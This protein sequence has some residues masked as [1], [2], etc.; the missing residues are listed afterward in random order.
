ML[1]Q[2]I[3]GKFPFDYKQFGG[4]MMGLTKAVQKT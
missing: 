1:Y 3:Y 2:L 4:G